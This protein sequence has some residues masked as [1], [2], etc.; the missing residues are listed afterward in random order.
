MMNATAI[1]ELRGQLRGDVITPDDG[2]YDNT[3]KVYNASI[4]KKPAAFAQCVDAADVMAA[5]RFAR[6]HNVRVSVR[7]GGHNAGGLGVAD[8]A[9]VIDLAPIKYVHVDPAARTVRV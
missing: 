4:D 8:D 6:A 3:R 1:A 7:G 5:V 2:R 9:L